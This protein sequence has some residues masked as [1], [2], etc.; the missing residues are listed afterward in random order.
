M[1]IPI[2]TSSDP[3]SNPTS[4]I[5]PPSTSASD[6]IISPSSPPLQPSLPLSELQKLTDIS[7]IQLQL[8]YLHFEE[9]ELDSELD[10]IL[11]SQNEI[12]KKLEGLRALG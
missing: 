11:K 6:Q 7:E 2:I 1:P 3:S 8:R 9:S 12:E 5:P 4:S 10:Q